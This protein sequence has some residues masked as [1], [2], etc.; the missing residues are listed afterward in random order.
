M[1]LR[2]LK[3][4]NA[5]KGVK[6]K[7]TRKNVN[8]LFKLLAGR[9]K[10]FAK[11]AFNS[12]ETKEN[13]S[14]N[15]ILDCL[16]NTEKRGTM[17]ITDLWSDNSI[18]QV[19]GSSKMIRD[20]LVLVQMASKIATRKKLRKMTERINPKKVTER[21]E[22]D[23]ENMQSDFAKFP[24]I[25]EFSKK[26]EEDEFICLTPKLGSFLTESSIRGSDTIIEDYETDLSHLPNKTSVL[27]YF[28]HFGL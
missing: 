17:N 9:T 28:L 26:F 10:T 8:Q 27:K 18:K 14:I 1:N 15:T 16:G 23:Q 5:K 19:L 12:I 3:R 4:D 20:K 2:K 7:Q 21:N 6:F 24:S 22:K 25:G 13:A 11:F